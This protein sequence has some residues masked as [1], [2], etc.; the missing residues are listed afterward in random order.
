MPIKFLKDRHRA[1]RIGRIRLGHQETKKRKDGTEVQYPVAD[2]F[3]VI[4]KELVEHYGDHPTTLNIRFIWDGLEQTFPHYLRRYTKSGLR[5]LGDGEGIIYRVNDDGE[6]DV[7]D[8]CAVTPGRKVIMDDNVVRTVE[9]PGDQCPHYTN[10]ECKP[11]GFL[12]FIIEEHPRL[13]YY[14][15]VCHQ[16]AVIGVKT[17]LLLCLQM[18]G[19]LTDIPFLLHRGE[20]EQVPVRTPKGVMDMPVRTQWI[21]VEPSWFQQHFTQSRAILVESAKFRQLQAAQD[22][23][24]L[25]GP[26]WESTTENGALTTQ[27]EE[28]LYDNEGTEE[29]EFQEEETV[30]ETE[31]A[32]LAESIRAQL[33]TSAESFFKDRQPS[34]GQLGLLV[35]KVS[36]ALQDTDDKPRH[37]VFRWLWGE[38]SSKKLSYGAVGAMLKRWVQGKDE[39][40]DYPLA[41]NAVAELAVI[42][43]QAEIEAGQLQFE[44]A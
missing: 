19:R 21:E 29:G 1:Q 9:C 18:F 28:A 16:K 34:D 5:C 13:G 11:T 2:P 40:G 10:G 32:N 8:Y 37:L 33:Q 6:V 36:E 27:F 7:S 30:T 20:E 42:K 31:T 25:Y 43:K 23:V 14:D 44:E 17:Q 15:L 38:E 24:D 12:R 41:P 3:F 39:S 4:P 22:I 26:D 35:G